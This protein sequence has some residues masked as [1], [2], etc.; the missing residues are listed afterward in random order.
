MTTVLVER[1]YN[2]ANR[3]C[4]TVARA[5]DLPKLVNERWGTR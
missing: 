4:I 5:T 1:I 2:A 3:D